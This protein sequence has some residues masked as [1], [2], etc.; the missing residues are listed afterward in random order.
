MIETE[1]LNIE[2]KMNKKKD[3][4]DQGAE[5]ASCKNRHL[6][7][8][9]SDHQDLSEQA[10]GKDRQRAHQRQ[11]RSFG[12]LGIHLLIVTKFQ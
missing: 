4:D 5:W 12:E 10:T 7:W 6:A 9:H 3:D 2:C 1:L 8:R 11:V